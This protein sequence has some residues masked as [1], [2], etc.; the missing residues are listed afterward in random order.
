M[1]YR[2]CFASDTIRCLL[3]EMIVPGST[4]WNVAFG[5]E[6][7]EV[8]NDAE[9]MATVKNLAQNMAWLMKRLAVAADHEVQQV[10]V[11]TEGSK[12]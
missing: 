8:R 5:R 6:K 7:G 1:A 9:G 10:P 11:E 4:Y 2:G 12:A 3:S